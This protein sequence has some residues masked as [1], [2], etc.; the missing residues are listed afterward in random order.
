MFFFFSGRLVLGFHG[1]SSARGPMGRTSQ[2]TYFPLFGFSIL[3]YFFPPFSGLLLNSSADAGGSTVG[4]VRTTSWPKKWAVREMGTRPFRPA[5]EKKTQGHTSF[6]FICTMFFFFFYVFVAFLRCSKK[7]SI[8]GTDTRRWNEIYI[9]VRRSLRGDCLWEGVLDGKIRC[10]AE[11][12][13]GK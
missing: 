11:A 10:R 6:R 1:L 13:I 4:R 3:Y 8:R 12:E 2:K 7:S 9:S 5:Q